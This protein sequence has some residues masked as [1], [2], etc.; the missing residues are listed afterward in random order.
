MSEPLKGDLDYC[1]GHPTVCCPCCS[2]FQ[3]RL[4]S[5]RQEVMAEAEKIARKIENI[6][7]EADDIEYDTEQ[8]IRGVIKDWERFKAAHKEKSNG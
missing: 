5:A 1:S 8:E 6:L 3:K 7:S 2:E 4:T